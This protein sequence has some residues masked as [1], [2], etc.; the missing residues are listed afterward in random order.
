MGRGPTR[1]VV[2][3]AGSDGSELE[4]ES[5]KVLGETGFGDAAVTEG[6]VADPEP[7]RVFSA[8]AAGP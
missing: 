2:A 4:Q 7:L 5:E 1:R 3:P 6:V 8:S